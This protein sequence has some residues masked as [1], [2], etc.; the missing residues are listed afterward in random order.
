MSST[1]TT[2]LP[3]PVYGQDHLCSVHRRS[4]TAEMDK[5]FPVHRGF[6]PMSGSDPYAL[7]LDDVLRRP[8]LVAISSH[9]HVPLSLQR[10]HH[11]R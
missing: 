5:L 8:E 2:I 3:S 11:A 9:V 6:I 10:K 4:H 1:D 7:K